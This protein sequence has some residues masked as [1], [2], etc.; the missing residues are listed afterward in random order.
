MVRD[1]RDKVWVQLGNE[2]DKDRSEWIAE[3]A[4]ESELLWGS[5]GYKICVINWSTGEPEPEHWR[6]PM[7]LSM[8]RLAAEKRNTFAVG[9]HE[10]SL[11]T[12]DI[13][14]GG[15]YLVGRFEDLIAACAENNIGHPTILITEFGWTQ[16]NIPAQSQALVDIAKIA[17]KYGQY[18]TLLGAGVWY[19]GTGFGDIANKVQPLIVPVTQQSKDYVAPPQINP[20][21]DVPTPDETFEEY[22]WRRSVELQT[23]S[24]NP[25]AL[26]QQ[27]IF[28]DDYNIVEGE[29]WDNYDNIVYAA[30]AGEN[31]QTGDRRVYITPVPEAGQPWLPPNWFDD[32]SDD[33]LQ[34]FDSVLRI[35]SMHHAVTVMVNMKDRILIFIRLQ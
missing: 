18:P 34:G 30:Q 3:W 13:N 19:L 17:Q 16:D 32:P 15:G 8:L 28:A 6:A 4:M 21:P 29:F 25:N 14:A 20:D 5:L 2:L 23:V 10:Y 26:L 1:H 7:M 12:D 31:L 9:L 11:T 24:L 33:V 27:H 22:F 35:I